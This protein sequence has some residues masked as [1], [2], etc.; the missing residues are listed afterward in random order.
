[1]KYTPE[2]SFALNG[3]FGLRQ[4]LGAILAPLF[5]L[6]PFLLGAPEGLSD[7]GWRTAGVGLAMATLWVSEAIPIPVTALVPLIFFPIYGILNIEETTTP[8]ANPLI[9]LFM[10]GFMIALAIQR[11]GLHRRIA[12]KTIS[13]MGTKPRSV[14][15]GFMVATAFLSMWVSNTATVLMMLPI[16][17]SVVGL[18]DEENS[19]A[20]QAED[21]GFGTALML[22]IAYAASIGGIGTF[23]GTP[24]NAL[25]AGFLLETYGIRL[26]FG[27]WMLFSIPLVVLS[28]PIVHFILT[29]WVF[30]IHRES[31]GDVGGI[32]DRELTAM[33]RMSYEEKVV[34]VVGILTGLAWILRPVLNRYIPML[35]DAGIGMLGGLIMFLIPVDLSK[36]LFIMDWG[37]AK[38]LPWGIFLLF[39]GG[40]SLAAGIQKSGLAVF[41]GKSSALLSSWPIFWVVV[42]ISALIL[43]LTEVNSNTATV[44]TFLPIV[45]AMAEGMNVDP[46]LL[47]IP[48]TLVAS[49][50]FML[51][52]ATP[53]NAVVF[54]SGCVTLPQ[55]VR[56]GVWMNLLF[57]ILIPL[58]V[59]SLG[60]WVFAMGP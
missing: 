20:G 2:S 49:C 52:I 50:A 28:L 36:R 57:L 33:G 48:I 41:L 32:I 29:R 13:F 39:G 51:P 38:K 10:G 14:I 7:S 44:S 42:L 30:K 8:Y 17:L 9:F 22:S 55:M 5:L 23:I 4:W 12:L 46:L 45:A 54:G 3:V 1:M 40:L 56:A 53:P 16:A 34:A 21:N 26:G 25:M 60:K 37:E 24:P 47:V 59:F 43:L 19:Q 11:W 15:M 35:S 27:Q 31:V 58:F 6:M 18:L